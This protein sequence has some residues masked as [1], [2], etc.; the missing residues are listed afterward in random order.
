MISEA[1]CQ[2]TNAEAMEDLVKRQGVTAKPLPP[3]VVKVLR[4]ATA[5]VLA[6]DIKDP[7]TKKVHDSYMAYMAKYRAWAAYSESVY[8]DKILA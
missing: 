3:E 2:R 6:E 7:L 4:E 1:W 5:K 8:H